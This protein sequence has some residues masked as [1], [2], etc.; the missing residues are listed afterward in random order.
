MLRGR[1]AANAGPAINPADAAATI[2]LAPNSSTVLRCL[3]HRDPPPVCLHTA[4]EMGWHAVRAPVRQQGRSSLTK[5]EPGQPR[6]ALRKRMTNRQSLRCW[7]AARGA[8]WFPR[9]R[10]HQARPTVPIRRAAKMARKGRRRR[11]MRSQR[12]RHP[13]PGPR[14]PRGARHAADL[15][16]RGGLHATLYQRQFLALDRETVATRA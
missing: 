4:T 12:R 13:G 11:A 2:T 7:A 3:S 9:L 10:V 8:R 15:V 1:Y 5:T 14:P 16:D 6:F